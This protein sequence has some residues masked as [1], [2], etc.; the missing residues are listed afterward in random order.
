MPQAS[1]AFLLFKLINYLAA[2]GLSCSMRDLQPLLQHAGF[3]VV[4]CGI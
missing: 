2:L 1:E 3:S 4:A